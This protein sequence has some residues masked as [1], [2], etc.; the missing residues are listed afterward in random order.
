ME[1]PVPRFRPRQ[2][3]GSPPQESRSSWCT[4]LHIMY[5][6]RQRCPNDTRSLRV[7]HSATPMTND[8]ADDEYEFAFAVGLDLDYDHDCGY[9]SDHDHDV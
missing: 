8:D 1:S 2:E 7:S 6:K 3:A 5:S 4:V 9:A